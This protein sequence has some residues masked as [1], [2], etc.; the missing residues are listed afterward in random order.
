[1]LSKKFTDNF[2]FH[3]KRG[4]FKVKVVIFKIVYVSLSNLYTN[5]RFDSYFLT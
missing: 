4:G 1:M 5:V 2:D 3:N